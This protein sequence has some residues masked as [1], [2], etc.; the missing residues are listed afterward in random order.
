VLNNDKALE[1]NAVTKVHTY[2]CNSKNTQANDKQ[3]KNLHGT[4]S[5]R[6]RYCREG[7]K[8]TKIFGSI[9]LS[10]DIRYLDSSRI[11]LFM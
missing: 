10:S 11:K 4:I 1:Q 9:S 6:T 8:T 3:G 2:A 5:T 7:F